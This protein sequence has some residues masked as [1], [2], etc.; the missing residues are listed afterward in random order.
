MNT[1]DLDKAPAAS[2]L[3]ERTTQE[4]IGAAFGV[5][6]VLGYGFLE[7]VYQRAMQAELLQRGVPV[8]IEHRI[9]VMY[10]GVNV[11]DYAADLFVDAKVVVEIKVA[12]AYNAADEAQLLNEL[13]ATGTKVGML[14]NFGSSKVEFRRLVF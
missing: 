1:D 14:I 7:K 12:S 4:I 10:K 2:L 6:N 3:H 8:E 9:T 11:G 13:K 5:Y